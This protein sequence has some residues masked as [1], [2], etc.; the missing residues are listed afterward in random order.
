MNVLIADDELQARKRLTRL[1]AGISDVTLVGEC[2]SGDEVL[3]QLGDPHRCDPT[4]DVLLLDIRMPGLSG[5]ETKALLG[6]EGPYVIFATAH[7][8]HALEAFD[9]G[10]VDYLLKPVEPAKLARALDR[11][12]RM[13]GLRDAAVDAPA[14]QARD[15]DSAERLAVETRSGVVLLEPSEID[16]AV[17]DAE[18]VTLWTQRGD[19]IVDQ[20]LQ[21]LEERLSARGPGCDFVRAH[22]RVLLNLARVQR[23]ESL[24]TGGYDAYFDVPAGGSRSAPV[25]RQAARALRRRFGL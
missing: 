18:L 11:A 7:E 12:A 9:V 1:L 10:A 3:A 19:F 21:R 20:S 25:S 5:L 6:D 8:E 14:G 23:F 22:R 15:P 4:V 17:L 24:P 2:R 16:C 13:L